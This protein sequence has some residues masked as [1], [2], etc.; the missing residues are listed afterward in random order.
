MSAFRCVHCAWYDCALCWD[1]GISAWQQEGR[2]RTKDRTDRKDFWMDWADT[3]S[4]GMCV[5]GNRDILGFVC[6]GT[7]LPCLQD[8]MTSLPCLHC[9]PSLP[10]TF[11][12]S[13]DMC[14]YTF[15][16]ALYTFFCPCTPSQHVALLGPA[17]CEQEKETGQTCLG[18]CCVAATPPTRL[19]QA[20]KLLPASVPATIYLLA[21]ACP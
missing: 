10:I 17:A 15:S 6:A 8:S 4:I 19:G 14:L 16:C 20:C 12:P 2:D 3:L 5:C 7:H 13:Q 1:S 18:L 9:L 21:F 11:P